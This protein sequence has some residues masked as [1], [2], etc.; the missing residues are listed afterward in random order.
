LTKQGRFGFDPTV[1]HNERLIALNLQESSL[2]ELEI[3]DVAPERLDE[4]M[5]D[6]QRLTVRLACCQH[7]D[8]AVDSP[9]HPV[10]VGIGPRQV[11]IR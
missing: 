6:R 8:A 10:L 1:W 11:V 2:E 7:L 5:L 3:V 4:G 9:V